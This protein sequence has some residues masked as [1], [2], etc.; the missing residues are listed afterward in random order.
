MSRKY[1]RISSFDKKQAA[2]LAYEY[3]YDEF[4]VLLLNSRGITEP[5]DVAEFLE[6]D[7]E[8][9]DP[10][11]IK[12]MEKAVN[13]IRKAIDTNEKI[14]V[15]GDYDADGVTATALLYL[16]LEATGANVTYYIPSRMEEG[17]GLH[18]GAIDMLCE[19]GVKLIIT[20][21]NGINS[22]KE[23]DYIKEK[24]MEIVITDHHQPGSVMPH[25]VAVVNPHRADDHSP[26]KDLAGVGVAFKLAAALED[27]DC[28]AIL[29][30]FADIIA[31]GTIADIVPLKGENRILAVRGIEAINND[32]RPGIAV[33][34]NTA[35]FADKDFN[36]SGVAFSIAP[37]INAAGRIE[38]AVTALRL[39]LADS[40]EEAFALAEKLD[41]FNT[42][43][44]ETE[45]AIAN[46]A[47]VRIESDDSLKYAKV[48]VVEGDGWHA[49]VIGIVASKLVDRY[50]KPAMVIAKDGSGEAKGSC[51][52]IEGFS[53]FD[54]LS[55]VSDTLVRFGGH[56]LAAGFTVKDEDIDAFRRRVNEYA[57]TLPLFYPVL[58]LDC[59]LNPAS[60]NLSL[61]ES[62]SLLEPFG[63]ENHQP[64]FGLYRVTVRSVKAI[65]NTGKHMRLGFEKQGTMFSAVYFGMNAEE[66]PYEPG[67]TVDLA[68]TVDKNEFRG[69]VKAAVYIKDVK[70]SAF[71]D[72]RYFASES[73][74]SKARKGTLL[75]ERERTFLCPDRSFCAAVFRL[76]KNAGFCCMPP[77]LIAVK[78][79]YGS[80]MTCRVRITLDAFCELGLLTYKDG[81]YSVPEHST[82]VSLGSSEILKKLGYRD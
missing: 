43:R 36:S 33:L 59:R 52:S 6:R 53:L 45:A 48:L 62:L 35:G 29:D 60:V 74:Y 25:A 37:R 32:A 57:D 75:T 56:T 54:A 1:W 64:V 50:G 69:E 39:L 79:G 31:I 82:K 24:G 73:L 12:D 65:G 3:G 7:T 46:E 11:L 51:R 27:G 21:D 10:F 70:A 77:E 78:L 22:V 18:P 34:K 41:G 30:D 66:F 15:Y 58:N 17:Y 49:G 14:A 8:L 67:D 23:A 4:A 40:E 20:V 5:E 28:E 44:Q 81:C 55:E 2:E 26:F 13:C 63:A 80:E 9:S 16:Y 68:V 47:I 61:I 42:K 19:Q 72:D 76:V 71:T 38:S